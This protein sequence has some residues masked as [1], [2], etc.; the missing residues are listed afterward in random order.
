MSEESAN[1]ETFPAAVDPASG[2]AAA[3]K[4]PHNLPA[5]QNLLGALLI[6]NDIMEKIDDRL[7]AEHFYDPLHGRIFAT[8]M[9]MI[10]RGQ[11]ANPV[12]LK[13]FFSGTDDGPDGAIED[14]L[15]ELADGVISLAQSADYAVTIYE[16][17][18]R[19]ELIRIGDDVIED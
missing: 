8:M 12:T 7:R 18:L 4:M 6:D 13:S 17:H 5:E 15:G 16:A 10:D 1:I 14:Y 19:R 11:L 3:R 2:L 9:R